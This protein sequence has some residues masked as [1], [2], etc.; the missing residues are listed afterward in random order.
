MTGT[1]TDS[2]GYPLAGVPFTLVIIDSDTESIAPSATW[3][4]SATFVTGSSGNFGATMTNVPARVGH[5]T[6]VN[7][8]STD[9]YDD[10]VTGIVVGSTTVYSTYVY[11]LAYDTY[12]G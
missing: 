9:Y 3:E 6:W 5:R 11:G 10:G 7:L 2:S 8:L 12:N 4:T 1:L